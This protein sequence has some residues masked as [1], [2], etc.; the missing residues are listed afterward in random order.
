MRGEAWPR[1]AADAHEAGEHS[2]EL[3]S[4]ENWRN[5]ANCAEHNVGDTE[6]LFTGLNTPGRVWDTVATSSSM[7]RHADTML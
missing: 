2:V 6:A 4:A 3:L 7:A 5:Q 1:N